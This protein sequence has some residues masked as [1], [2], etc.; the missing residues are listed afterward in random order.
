MAQWDKADLLARLKRT[1][2]R[3][4]TDE[5]KGPTDSDADAMLYALLT[6][7]QLY[8]TNELAT[9]VPDLAGLYTIEQLTTADSGLTYSFSV[10]P[11][12]H[13]EIR[14]SRNG[15]LLVPGAEWDPASDFIPDGKKIRFPGGITK[16]F[17]S[18]PFARYVKTPTFI[19]ASTEPTLQPPQARL[20]VVYHAAGEW[21][22]RGGLRD[23]QPYWD[24]ENRAAF[25]DPLHGQVGLVGALK[26]SAFLIGAAGVP[27]GMGDW[28]RHISTGEGYTRTG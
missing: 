25:G 12:G 2:A 8:W 10:E 17:A 1:L 13:Y 19:D 26:Q 15:R 9:H 6:E 7:G 4:G 14:E 21:A 16:Q 5:D 23:P 11:L 3:P 20:L 27:S 24:L 28:W 22:A 18:G